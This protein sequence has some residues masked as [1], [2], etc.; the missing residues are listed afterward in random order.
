MVCLDCERMLWFEGT[1][2]RDPAIDAWL[3]EQTPDLAVIARQWFAEMRGCG[4]CAT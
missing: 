1:A 3:D 2:R 4:G